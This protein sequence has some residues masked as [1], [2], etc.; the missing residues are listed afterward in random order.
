VYGFKNEAEVLDLANDKPYGLNAS[1]WSRDGKRAR[2]IA[3]RLRSG[4]VNINEAYGSTFGSV[5]AAIGGMG[6]SGVGRRNGAEGIQRYTEEQTIARQTLL[7][8]SPWF[9]MSQERFAKLISF[10]LRMLKRL[11]LR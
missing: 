4:M 5:G 8:L 3:L 6:E 11:R 2:E 9:G 7:P 1:V 10:L